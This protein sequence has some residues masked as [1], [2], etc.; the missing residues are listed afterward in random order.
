MSKKIHISKGLDINLL[1][2]ADKVVLNALNI[3]K[4]AVKPADFIGITPKLLVQEGDTVKAGDP[5]FFD[6]YNERVLFTSPVSGTIAEIRRGEKRVIEE[7]CISADEK[8][9]YA[10]F[11]KE[12]IAGLNRELIIEKL[13]KSGA[14]VSLR[15]RPYNVIA[16]PQ[17]AP[18]AIFISGFDSAPLAPD[19]DLAV[20]GRGPVFQAG[21]DVLAKLTAGKVHLNLH[22]KKNTS[23]VFRNSKNVQ[24][25]WFSGKHPAGNVGVQIHHIDPINKGDIVWHINP[26][27]VIT[28]GTLFLEGKYCPER[29]IALTGSEL[30]N[31]K[32]YRVF[33]GANVQYLVRDHIENENVRYISGNVL[34]GKRIAKGGYLGHYH[35]QVTVLPEGDHYEFLGWVTP[36]I[37]KYSFS[38][39][40]LSGFLSKLPVKKKY[41]ID[42]NLHGG[43]RALVMTGEFEKVFPMDIYP[44]Q[45]I[46]ACIIEDIDQ[47][48]QLGIYEVDEEDFALCEFIDTSK[49][50]IQTIIRKGLDLVRKEMS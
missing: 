5:L 28:I 4:Y 21:L 15:Q 30:L 22:T 36:G 39:T 13:L 23:G 48:E 3:R 11:G 18:K 7:V 24:I 49:T 27:E 31:R 43:H 46:K 12:E 37:E 29:I 38:R 8:I 44:M 50:E 34:T 41:K 25:N 35:Y 20:H 17:D 33:A 14:W 2:D 32:Y 6:K 42:T 45:L 9:E 26:Q 40:F 1:G 16:N 19:Y 10:D 47:M